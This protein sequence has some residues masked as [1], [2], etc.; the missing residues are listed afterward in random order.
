MQNVNLI[1]QG[2]NVVGAIVE[3]LVDGETI[4]DISLYIVEG[5]T[6]AKAI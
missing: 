5:R 2:N 6:Y 4:K 1:E 3:S